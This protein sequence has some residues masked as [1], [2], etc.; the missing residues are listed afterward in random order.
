MRKVLFIGI[1]VYELYGYWTANS[2]NVKVK[3]VFF[4]F[5]LMHS[6]RYE[7]FRIF[8]NVSV[9]EWF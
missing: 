4:F 7:V 3:S 9:N 2:F 6:Y 8:A 5:K 1:S